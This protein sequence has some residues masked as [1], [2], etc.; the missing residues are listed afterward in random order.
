MSG[1]YRLEDWI[2]KDRGEVFFTGVQALARLPVEQLRVDRAAGHNTAAFASGYPGSPLGGLDMELA[3][4]A[5]LA[6]DLPIVLRPALNEEL[7]VSAVMGSQLASTRPDARYDGVVG[8][9]Y[10]KA[11]GFDRASDALRHAV[12]TGT[13][14]LGGAVAIVGDDPAAKSSTIPSSSDATMIDLHLPILYPADVSEALDLGRHAIALSR[15]SGL[16]VGLK[17]VSAVADG[18]GTIRL[19]P[20]RVRPIMPTIDGETYQCRP[21]AL[22]LSAH[23]LE[24]EQQ[25][26]GVRTD[27]AIAYGVVNELN[28]V[29]VPAPS[30]WLGVIASGLTYLEA[31]DAFRRLGLDEAGLT[32]AGVRVLQMRMP[33]PFD[34]SVVRAFASGLEE[35]MVIE[36]MNPSLERLVRDALYGT[37]NQ[38]LV[39]GKLD[40]AGRPQMPGFGPLLADRMVG[41]LRAALE[42][43]LGERLVPP[44]PPRERVLLSLHDSRS[45]AFC[46]GCPHN[47]STRVPEGTLV[48]AG[49]GCHT[50]ALLGSDGRAGEIVCVA[51]MGNEG[52][53]WIGM[54]EFVDTAHFTQNLGDGTFFH[55]GQLAIQAAV[56][57][58]VDITFKLLLN[59]SVAMTGG[60]RPTGQR[61]LGDICRM[62]QA[63]GVARI[64]VTTDDTHRHPRHEIPSGVEVWDRNRLAEAHNLLAAIP[65]VTVLIHDQ[66]CAAELR[67][68]RRRNPD[69]VLPSRV[70]INDRI[71]EGCGDCAERS[72]CLSVQPYD[73]PLGRR[74]RI[75]QATCN[76]DQSCLD[77]DCPSFLAVEPAPHRWWH[78]N[79]RFT[80]TAA[81]ATSPSVRAPSGTPAP[82]A[83]AGSA[84]VRLVGV[85]GTGVV[86]AAQIVA[87]A[88]L[89]DGIEVHGLDQTGLSQKAGPVMSDLVFESPDHGA[90]GSQI[91]EGQAD[92]LIALDAIVA[93]TEASLAAA[94]TGRTRLVGSSSFTP[95][96][97]MILHPERATD[98]PLD[99]R[100]RI[101]DACRP[102]AAWVDAAAVAE[103]LV[104][105]PATANLV[106]VGMA[107]QAGILPVSPDSIAQA[108]ELNRVSID[109]NQAAFDWGR[110]AIADPEAVHR[111]LARRPLP[112]ERRG[113]AAADLP[114]ALRARLASLGA[115]G[116]DDELVAAVAVRL[117]ELVGFD[118]ERLAAEYLDLV[119]RT[120]AA[121]QAVAESSSALVRAVALELYRVLAYKDEY[122]VARLLVDPVT[123]AAAASLVEGP[124]KITWRLHP[125]LLRALGMDRKI[126]VG[127]WAAPGLA[128]LSRG[129]RLRGTPWDPFGHTRVR[130]AERELA[131]EYRLAIEEVIAGLTP[132]RLAVAIEIASLPAA[133]RGYEE[134]KL[135]GIKRFHAAR[136]DG[137]ARFRATMVTV[138]TS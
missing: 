47:R 92:G 83:R 115:A 40:R 107:V 108:I 96:L 121:E 54:S 36:E 35:V 138:Q 119:V 110:V 21:D 37:P 79:A 15:A 41:P 102:G 57:A 137:L 7:G 98:D 68:D 123:L 25:L 31:L 93:A 103:R 113:A 32:S 61:G 10:G 42:H 133:V 73:T 11:P 122:E 9:W 109:A 124:A 94:S 95:T 18:S 81:L 8:L 50:M 99:T 46:S 27:V 104:G 14:P 51:A 135:E 90:G 45:P 63:Q 106:V 66:P 87:T 19:D 12:F 2:T 56:D 132:K 23:S 44:S 20:D 105:A 29:T 71:C 17:I 74:T 84:K 6:S 86:T 59:G 78:R 118:G 67:R 65:G 75:D 77:G 117:T 88:A 85:G 58:G 4:A 101:E 82:M 134:R 128:L 52:A 69:A 16:W 39:T 80:G 28:R 53:P 100:R 62:L 3:R 24:I 112:G 33:I 30:A 129:K 130:R 127:T 126:A 89:L 72:G 55:S 76:L 60:Q 1:S 48:G 131:D 13:S 26:R 70:L 43:R 5:R 49:I 91:G 125:P 114:A 120:A 116:A 22:L 97:T 38:P 111:E 136:R 64:I 34:P